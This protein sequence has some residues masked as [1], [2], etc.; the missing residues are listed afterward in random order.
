VG[1]GYTE[2]IEEKKEEIS[3]SLSK[4]NYVESTHL[5]LVR[6]GETDY[7]RNNIIQGTRDV[8]L[9]EIGRQQ[10]HDLSERLVD[11]PIHAAYSSY[12]QRAYETAQIVARP[13][14]LPV[15]QYAEL[16]EMDFGNFEGQLYKDV[17]KLW[18]V[19]PE[20]WDN[21]EVDRGF[22]NGENPLQVL[23]RSQAIFKSIID[24]HPAETVLVVTHGRL[25]RILLS[26]WF[27]MGL[28]RMNEIA[29]PNTVV[30]Y[31][32]AQDEIIKPVVINDTDHLREI[33]QLKQ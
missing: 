30:Y 22:E 17:K 4:N 19:I 13:H 5:L 2:P 9:N 6:H 21:G 32:M 14:D 7:N 12:L 18:D 23:Q 3:N 31:V 24:R 25:M 1:K 8:P 33:F 11:L 26:D 29:I 28:S 10:A 20:A 15:N 16:N 27:G